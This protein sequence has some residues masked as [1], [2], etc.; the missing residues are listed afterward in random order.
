MS[1]VLLVDDNP[2]FRLGLR[3]VIKS[4]QPDLSVMESETLLGARTA[5]RE[6]TGVALVILDIKVPDCGGFVG[7]FEL[8]REFPNVPVVVC[9]A[10][11]DSESVSRAVAFG[12]AGY[13]S[14]SAPCEAIAR[15]LKTSLVGTWTTG[16]IIAN[17]NQVNP[18]AALTPAQLRVLKGLKRGLRNKQIAFELGLSE[19]T[20]KAYMSVLYR[21]LGVGSRAEALVLLQK[22]LLELDVPAARERA[23]I[24]AAVA[25]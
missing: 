1:Q 3:E 16:P 9:S 25:V 17:E 21:K 12:A 18:I 15:M 6:N 24:A 14:K 20:V 5:L 19:K 2:L 4:A 13:I 11:V 10:N 7:L 8:R 22:V 23:D